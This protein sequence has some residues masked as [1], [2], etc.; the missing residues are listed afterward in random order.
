MLKK[1]SYDD[2]FD[3]EDIEIDL[4]SGGAV[5]FIAIGVAAV[6]LF[7]ASAAFGYHVAETSQ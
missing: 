4:V 6:A 3:L 5:P 7:V 2:I 1:H